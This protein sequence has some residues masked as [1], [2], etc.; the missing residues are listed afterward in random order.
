VLES[1]GRTQDEIDLG[2]QLTHPNPRV[3]LQL[4]V[5]LPL[6][7]KRDIGPWLERLS[8]DREPA[9]RAGAVRVASERKLLYTQWADKLAATDPDSTV[10]QVAT[11]H[12]RRAAG[13][14]T[15]S[16]FEP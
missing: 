16:G 3:R 8:R 4:L 1:R 2:R 14:S 9:V 11:F 7:P 13:L 10:R 5:D 12:R 6:E 15:V